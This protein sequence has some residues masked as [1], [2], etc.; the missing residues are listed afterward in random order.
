MWRILLAVLSALLL[1]LVLLVALIRYLPKACGVRL[2]KLG[3]SF[4]GTGFEAE[5]DELRQ[6]DP[7]QPLRP[8]IL[9]ASPKT[10]QSEFLSDA[11]L[12]GLHA[13]LQLHARD[14]DRVWIDELPKEQSPHAR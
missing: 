3:L 12:A 4:L 11:H 13:R 8:A 1:A 10:E 2:K 6:P 7:D 5:V 9:P 14:G